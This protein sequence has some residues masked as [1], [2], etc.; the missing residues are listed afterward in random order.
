MSDNVAVSSVL[1]G[2]LSNV[3]TYSLVSVD[4]SGSERMRVKAV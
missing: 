3:S 1:T 2:G 4:E